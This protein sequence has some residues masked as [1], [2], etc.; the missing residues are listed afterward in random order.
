MR[1]PFAPRAWRVGAIG[2]LLAAV[3][4][5]AEAQQTRMTVTGWPI[6]VT[7]TTGGDFEGGAVPLGTTSITV[8]ARTNATPFSPRVTTVE[9]RCIPACP[10]TGTLPLAGVQWRRDDQVSWTTLTT[11]YAF[12]EQRQVTFNGATDAWT[13]TLEWRYL[14]NWITNPPTPATEFRIEF[15][16]IVTA[17]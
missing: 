12:V 15:T 4:V 17:P 11:G 5:F 13:R 1:A 9:V 7:G 2:V 8:D 10:R 16:L 14:L 6:T 3:P